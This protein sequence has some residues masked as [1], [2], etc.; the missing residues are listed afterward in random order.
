MTCPR[1]V[2]AGAYVLGALPPAQR[3]DYHQHLATCPYCRAEVADLAA[4]PGLLGRLDV[5]SAAQLDE[6][7]TPPRSLLPAALERLRRY[8]RR[9][10]W[11]IA[12]VAAAVVLLA[13]GGATSV[14]T[15]ASGPG[16]PA[17]APLAVAL[18]PMRASGASGAVQ[19]QIALVPEDG[20]TRIEMH[21]VYL[22][23]EPY[24][25]GKP[26]QLRLLVYPRGGGAPASTV[27]TWTAAPGDQIS[28]SG[29]T[30]LARDQIDH[31]AL[32][33]GDGTILLTYPVT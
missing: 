3:L 19:A 33:R 4:L 1:T 22:D 27:A 12:L 26:W 2:E 7:E 10:R 29:S 25:Q 28:V 6:A 31:V 24:D 17:T 30:R 14:V 20:G 32:A 9:L 16:V 5:N 23:S 11:R 8:R 21:C 15:L 13:A 18:S